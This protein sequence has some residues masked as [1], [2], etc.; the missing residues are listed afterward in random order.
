MKNKHFFIMKDYTLELNINEVC[1]SHGIVN[2]YEINSA[3]NHLYAIKMNSER[4]K[5]LGHF[6]EYRKKERK[7]LFNELL[8]NFFEKNEYYS[9]CMPVGCGI[10]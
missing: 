5:C 10:F 9:D 7:D 8:N 1:G 3:Y 6:A 4:T 2:G